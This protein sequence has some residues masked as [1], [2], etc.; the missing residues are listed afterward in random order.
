VIEKIVMP[1]GRI[2]E[3]GSQPYEHG[4]G[5]FASEEVTE[6]THTIGDPAIGESA[7]YLV[8]L[9]TGRTVEVNNAAEVWYSSE[10]IV[11]GGDE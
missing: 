4:S 8:K 9:S 1:S 3:V 7:G 10:R 5:V 6:I 2:F 11:V